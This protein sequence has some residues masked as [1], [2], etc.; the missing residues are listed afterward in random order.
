MKQS[1]KDE[2]SKI[3]AARMKQVIARIKVQAILDRQP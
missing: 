1:I 3:N 2:R